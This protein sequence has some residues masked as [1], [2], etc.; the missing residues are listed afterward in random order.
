MKTEPKWTTGNTTDVETVRRQHQLTD[1][2][3]ATL[4]ERGFIR[5]RR[6]ESSI[7]IPLTDTANIPPWKVEATDAP[8]PFWQNDANKLIQSMK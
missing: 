2:E 7:R 6:V 5:L 3:L 4:A 8:G 1:A